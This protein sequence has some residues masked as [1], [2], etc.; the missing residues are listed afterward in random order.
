M[1]MLNLR[2]LFLWGVLVVGISIVYGDENECLNGLHYSIIEALTDK[3][4]CAS[5]TGKK[6]CWS[7]CMKSETCISNDSAVISYQEKY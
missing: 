5:K 3:V 6:Y 7:Y 2:L 4:T 1:E